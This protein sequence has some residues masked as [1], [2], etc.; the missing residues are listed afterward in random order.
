MNADIRT[1]PKSDAAPGQAFETRRIPDSMI[2]Q[3]RLDPW[4]S[5]PK[6]TPPRPTAASTSDVVDPSALLMALSD[7]IESGDLQRMVALAENALNF[8][9]RSLPGISAVTLFA[10]VI[11]GSVS[12]EPVRVSDYATLGRSLQ[13]RAIDYGAM[14]GLMSGRADPT[15][16][17]RSLATATEWI[18]LIGRDFESLGAGEW[19]DM[20]R[21]FRRGGRINRFD[22]LDQLSRFCSFSTT[23]KPLDVSIVASLR[24]RL[25]PGRALRRVEAILLLD[26]ANT[27]ARNVACACLVDLH[28]PELALDHVAVSLL[29]PDAYVAKTAR[30]ALRE[31]GFTAES[32]LADEI[33]GLMGNRRADEASDH[34]CDLANSILMSIDRRIHAELAKLGLTVVETSAVITADSLGVAGR[35]RA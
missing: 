18:T 23:V 10:T 30:R 4:G 26:P 22:L 31:A 11:A 29:H 12:L 24:R 8:S 33:A 3:W 34:V 35:P 1:E 25:G 19:V 2:C 13:E 15:T 17:Q 6:L 27:A 20:S 14:F 16:L 7:A 32:G 5:L 21:L 9:M 28:Q